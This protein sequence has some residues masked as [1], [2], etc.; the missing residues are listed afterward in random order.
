[1]NNDT[2]QHLLTELHHRLSGS[3]ALDAETRRLLGIV[4]ADIDRLGATT[5]LSPTG[6]EALAVRFEADH[7]AI[8]ASLR[9]AV[10]LLGKAGI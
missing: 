3:P 4:S 6:I 5:Q 2:L 9:Q 1:M 7:P 10:D 8:S